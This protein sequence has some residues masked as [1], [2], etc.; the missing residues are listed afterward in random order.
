MKK[1][2]IIMVLGVAVC[3]LSNNALAG[4]KLQQQ[5]PTKEGNILF[6]LPPDSMVYQD[7][8]EMPHFPGGQQKLYRFIQENF[9]YPHQA[10]RDSLTG[11]VYVSF[12]VR[13][14]GS[15]SDIKVVKGPYE[16]LNN[17][18]I[19]LIQRMP[20]WIPAKKNNKNVSTKLILPIAY[21]IS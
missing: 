13:P 14:D 9:V 3:L 10:V 1:L 6:I 11:T 15:L 5:L 20:H 21:R 19:K 17:A 8:D 4:Q 7:V 12:I 16:I 2:K 18:A